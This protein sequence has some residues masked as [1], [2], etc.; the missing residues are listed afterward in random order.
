MKNSFHNTTRESKSEV[1]KLENKALTQEEK[2]LEIFEQSSGDLLSASDIYNDYFIKSVPITSIRRALSNLY[3]Q[4]Y[5]TKTN[6]KQEGL[7]GRPEVLWKR[8]N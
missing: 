6:H 2:I 3:H 5:I 4:G 8:I 1:A 7:Y